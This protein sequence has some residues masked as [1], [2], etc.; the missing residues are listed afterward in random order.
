MPK[1]KNQKSVFILWFI[2]I[3]PILIIGM[4]GYF[5]IK[6]PSKVS[7]FPDIPDP[8]SQPVLQN[9]VIDYDQ[10]NNETDTDSLMKQRKTEY[11]VEKGVDIIAKPDESLKIGDSVVSMQEIIDKI[12]IE[13]GRFVEKDLAGSL[14]AE[15]DLKPESVFDGYGIYI[16]QPGDNI[17]NIHFMFLNSYFTN[18]GITLSPVA[19]EPNAKGASSGVGKILKFSEN[20]VHIYSINDRKLETDINII[21][22]LSKIVVYNMEKIF[23]LL[24]TI[25][26][27]NIQ[28]IKF[29]GETIWIPSEQ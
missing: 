3:C 11:G 7:V 2:I 9:P 4:L 23:A 17:W 15:K 18:R 5:M 13:S 20:M 22:P 16:V 14:E 6:N 29:D 8:V 25:D 21:E 27:K 19:D 24:D 12:A 1:K 26:R 10:L 28:Q